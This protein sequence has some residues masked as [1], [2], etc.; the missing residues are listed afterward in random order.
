VRNDFTILLSFFL[1]PTSFY[2]TSLGVEGYSFTWSH[3]VTQPQSVGLLWKR[4]RPWPVPDNT[5]HSQQTNIH[6]PGG[7]RTSNPSRRTAADPR[8][9][10]LGHWNRPLYYCILVLSSLHWQNIST[11]DRAALFL[12]SLDHTQWHP[13]RRTPGRGFG[14][15]QRHQPDNTHTTHK[16]SSVSRAANELGFLIMTWTR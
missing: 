11:R 7:I 16:R 10:P 9:R 8:L 15:S 13:V 12:R 5:Q 2:L 3:T 4:D 6:A 14:V 1:S